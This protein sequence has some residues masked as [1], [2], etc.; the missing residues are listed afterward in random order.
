MVH[1]S[2]DDATPLYCEREDWADVVPIPQYEGVN[3]IAPIFY[4]PECA[5]LA[6]GAPHCG[7]AHCEVDKDATDYFRGIIKTGEMSPR[8]LELTEKII[9]MNAGHYSAW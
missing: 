9:R 7:L 6:L 3:P 8:A 5:F 4:N 1:I 2:G